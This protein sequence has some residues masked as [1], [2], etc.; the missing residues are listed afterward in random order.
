MIRF[1]IS[2]IYG[3]NTAIER[4][5][6]WTDLLNVQSLIGNDVAWCLLGDFNVCLGPEETSN[7]SNWSASMMEFRDFIVEVGV[8]DLNCTGPLFTWWDKCRHSPTYRKLDRCLINGSWM[9]QFPLSL[10][11]ILP[12]GLSDH[13]PVA[14][15]L[16]VPHDRIFKPF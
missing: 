9:T 3:F 12:R 11:S 5:S 7:G 16:G 8:T 1:F 4:R 15:K 6:L 2:F 13:C 14:V 10:A